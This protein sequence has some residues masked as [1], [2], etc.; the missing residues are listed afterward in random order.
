[1]SRKKRERD[2][3]MTSNITRRDFLNG[4]GITVGAS[5]LGY[6]PFLLDVPEGLAGEGDWGFGVG[7]DDCC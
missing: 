2:L 7:G 5:L 6:D 3:G 1:M 4:V